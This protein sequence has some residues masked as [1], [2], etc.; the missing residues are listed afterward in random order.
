MSYAATK[1]RLRQAQERR[2][3]ATLLPVLPILLPVESATG[4][5]VLQ[6]VEP[7]S[8]TDVTDVTDKSISHDDCN[9]KNIISDQ[10]NG[11]AETYNN[12]FLFP[13]GVHTKKTG[14]T[15]NIGNTQVV[16]ALPIMV[17][18]P[19]TPVTEIGNK[20]VTDPPPIAEPTDPA[21]LDAGQLAYYKQ[22]VGKI[23]SDAQMTGLYLAAHRNGFKLTSEAQG[24]WWQECDYKVTGCYG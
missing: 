14:N 1:E 7:T 9:K 17:E 10:P 12:F 24:A 3:Q 8:V 4:N 2:Q 21:P 13:F 5:S 19:V 23:V 22:F 18:T 11:T 16:E 15:G 20:P 6:V